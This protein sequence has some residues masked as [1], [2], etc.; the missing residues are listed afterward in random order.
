M[1]A[2][3]FPEI[4]VGGYPCFRDTGTLHYLAQA[5]TAAFGSLSADGECI[6]SGSLSSVLLRFCNSSRYVMRR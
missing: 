1:G 2:P 6:Y 4:W 3:I 5:A